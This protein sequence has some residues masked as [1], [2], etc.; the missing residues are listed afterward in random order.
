M[1]ALMWARSSS[2]FVL[3]GLFFNANLKA[4]F[5]GGDLLFLTEL[6]NTSTQQLTQLQSMVGTGKDTFNYLQEINSGVQEAMSMMNTMNNTLDPGVLS[7][8]QDPTSLLGKVQELYGQIPKTSEANLQQTVDQS[9]AENI[10][11]HNE[12]FKYAENVDPEAERIKEYSKTVSPAGA[13]RLTAQSLGMVIHVLNQIL[14]TNA[15]ILKVQSEQLALM[16]RKEKLN[17]AQFKSQYHGLAQA[18]QKIKPSY[19]LASLKR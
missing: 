6:I 12:A 1:G 2:L 7:D 18:F 10:H 16:N 4:D 11:L 19:G 8:L 9:V 17:S 13:G 5:W 15:A 14:R 3:L